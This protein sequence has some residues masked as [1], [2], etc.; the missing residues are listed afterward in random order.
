[1]VIC[2][3]I[4]N[5]EEKEEIKDDDKLNVENITPNLTTIKKSI[6][7]VGVLIK[8]VTTPKVKCHH[9]DFEAKNPNGLTMH[10]KAKHPNKS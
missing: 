5:E 2:H 7:K 6:E 10:L 3:S 9:C 8:E 4:L 1:M